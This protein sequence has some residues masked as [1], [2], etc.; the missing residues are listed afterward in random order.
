MGRIFRQASI[1][2]RSYLA[3]FASD[4]CIKTVRSRKWHVHLIAEHNLQYV[5]KRDARSPRSLPA[6]REQMNRLPPCTLLRVSASW[7]FER[8]WMILVLISFG[9]RR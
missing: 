7:Y 9:I 8:S 5:T 2:P 6:D 3:L 4:P 1:G